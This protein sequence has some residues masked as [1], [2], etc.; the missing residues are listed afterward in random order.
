MQADDVINSCS[1]NDDITDVGDAVSANVSAQYQ[2]IPFGAGNR[3]CPGQEFVDQLL[4][5]FLVELC[6]STV[7]ELENP[8]YK[9][10]QAAFPFADDNMPLKI[11][12]RE[13]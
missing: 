13:P 1:V 7:W 8:N 6:M 12:R 11:K 10:K 5:L 2:Y 4:R 9:I 3:A